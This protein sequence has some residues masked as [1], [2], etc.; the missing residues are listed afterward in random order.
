MWR[1]LREIPGE[2][3][4]P[5]GS[6][7]DPRATT[8]PI[9]QLPD[10]ATPGARQLGFVSRLIVATTLPHSKP[11]DNEF[12]RQSG[13]YDLCLLAPKRVG[14]PYG[15]YPR[16]ALAWM[17]TEVVKKKTPLLPLPPS[18]SRFASQ[19]GI[20]PSTG[21]KGTLCQLRDQ[22]LRLVNL[23][24]LC[25]D[26]APQPSP[27]A[28][29]SAFQGGGVHLVKRYLLWWDQPEAGDREPFILLSHDFCDEIIAHPIPIDL[30]VIRGLR[31]PLEIDVYMWLTYRSFRASRI[32]RPETIPWEAL[33]RQFGADY[34]EVRV[35]RFHLLKAIKTIINVYPELRL[36]STPG[37]LVLLPYPPHIL[38]GR[39]R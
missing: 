36:R 35:F 19:I 31:S 24:I 13:L 25:L 22:L 39:S 23:T 15:R 33:K 9:S 10:T 3:I 5:L 17:I 38:P 28:L 4:A 20:T 32:G 7:L 30:D 16:L 26:S 18:L 1:D 34:A 2:L 11:R 27:Y 21:A 37:G 8:R 12:T 14:L 6:S 29:P